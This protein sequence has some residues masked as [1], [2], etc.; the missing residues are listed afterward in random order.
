M[1]DDLGTLQQLQAF[2]TVDVSDVYMSL[3]PCFCLNYG[4]KLPKWVLFMFIPPPFGQILEVFFVRLELSLH[5]KRFFSSCICEFS[6]SH[7]NIMET[8][9]VKIVS[10]S[11]SKSK[12]GRLQDNLDL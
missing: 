4:C 6:A 7:E 1:E 12:C 3:S 11:T 8:M 5:K 9:S 10:K 2:A